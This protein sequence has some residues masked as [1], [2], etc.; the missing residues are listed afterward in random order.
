MYFL[1]VLSALLMTLN[2]AL[3]KVFQKT[4]KSDI[5]SLAMYNLVNALFACCFFYVSAGFRIT[6]NPETA[7]YALVYAAIICINLSAQVFAMTR[8]TVSLVTLMTVA[9]GMLIPAVFGIVYYGERLTVRLVLSAIL[10]IAATVIPFV[11][12]KQT[13]RI[14][15]VA[16]LVCAMLFVLSGASVILMQ[17]YARDPRVCDSQSFFLLTN[18]IIVV[19]CLGVLGVVL[20]KETGFG[21]ES[22]RALWHIFTGRQVLNIGAKTALA[23]VCSILQ[24]LI[25]RQMDAST[26][27]VL[28]S[29]MLLIG[30]T[31]V[32]AICFREKQD[33]ASGVAVVLAIAALVVNP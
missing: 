6:V 25:L 29:S 22:I 17:L 3:T 14:T 20:Q 19:L 15:P 8:V 12:Q 30:A 21:K 13:L 5:K 23:N 10:I 28:N 4:T 33:K 16:V 24:V 26:Y 7:V 1:L 18:G 2:T 31:A 9:G 27:A 11:G 32:S